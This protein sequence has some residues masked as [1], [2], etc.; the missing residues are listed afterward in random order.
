M[1]NLDF[2]PDNP[3]ILLTPGP[4]STSKGVR[5]ALLRDWCTWD[6]D[7]NEDIVQNIRHRLVALATKNTSEYTTVLMQGSGSFSIEATLGS[8]VGR[9]GKLLIISNGAYGERMIKMATV[10]RLNFTT[11]A[12]S[13]MGFN[14]PVVVS[15]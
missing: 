5:N 10:M 8:T 4:L 13:S 12:I 15:Q 2:I 3:Y 14:I 6:N 9:D 1:T 7:Y 11:F